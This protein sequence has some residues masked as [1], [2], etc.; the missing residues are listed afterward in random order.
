[1]SVLPDQRTASRIVG[2]SVVVFYGVAGAI[3][4][5]WWLDKTMPWFIATFFYLGLWAYTFSDLPRVGL[6]RFLQGSSFLGI[7]VGFLSVVGA[8]F[9]YGFFVR[10]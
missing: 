3:A 2:A 8:G 6:S 4:G 10:S 7:K 9:A 5:L 1:V